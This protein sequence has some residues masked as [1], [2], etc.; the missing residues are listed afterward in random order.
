MYCVCSTAK[1]PA[2][3]QDVNGCTPLHRAVCHRGGSLE[4]VQALVGQRQVAIAADAR[5]AKGSTALALS[6]QTCGTDEQVCEWVRG[7][8]AR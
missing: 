3:L 4:A 2:S 1:A 5:D 6:I 7:M 8:Q